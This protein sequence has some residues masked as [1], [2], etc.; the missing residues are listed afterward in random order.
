MYTLFST[1]FSVTLMFY[2][3]I[4]RPLL[5]D[6][7][8]LIYTFPDKHNKIYQSNIAGLLHVCYTFVTR[9]RRPRTYSVPKYIV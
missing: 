1:Y 7:L 2:F 3:D 8:V 4:I 5:F 6:K 9:F